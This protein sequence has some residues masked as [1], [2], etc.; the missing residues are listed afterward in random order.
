MIDFDRE[1]FINAVE[2][3][4]SRTG[5]SLDDLAVAIGIHKKT[6]AKYLNKERKETPKLPVFIKLFQVLNT[7]PSNLLINKGPKVI[8]ASS[9]DDFLE[10]VK[11]FKDPEKPAYYVIMKVLSLM[12]YEDVDTTKALLWSYAKKKGLFKSR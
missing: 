6:L 11:H 10:L 3:S 2:E 1:I 4:I 7:S 12:S 9:S 8:G 5:I